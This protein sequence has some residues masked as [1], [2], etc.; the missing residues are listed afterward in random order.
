M[1]RAQDKATDDLLATA[2]AQQNAAE[3]GEVDAAMPE[4]DADLGQ[5][6]GLAETDEGKNRK[7]KSLVPAWVPLIGANAVAKN[8]RIRQEAAA[9][10]ESK[11]DSGHR[12]WLLNLLRTYEFT[13]G[14]IRSTTRQLEAMQLSVAGAQTG[15]SALLSGIDDE[16]DAPVAHD[17]FSGYS[18]KEVKA[19]ITS[20]FG[21]VG[22]GKSSLLKTWAVMRPLLRGHR[23]VVFDKKMHEDAENGAGEGQFGEYTPLAHKLGV[24]PIRLVIGGGPD[25]SCVNLLDPAILSGPD[26]DAAS[27][28]TSQSKLLRAVTEEILGRNLSPGEGKALRIAHRRALSEAKDDGRVAVISDVIEKL[29]NPRAVDAE[30]FGG[31]EEDLKTWGR[32]PGME[33]ERMVEDDLVGLFDRETSPDVRLNSALTVFDLSALPE[34]GPALPVVMTIINTW[35]AHVLRNQG[36]NR[37]PTWLVVEEAWHLVHGSF[38]KVTRDNVKLSRGLGLASVFAFHHLTDIPDDSPAIAMIKD[39]DTVFCYR[40]SRRDDAEAVERLFDF[41]AGSAHA[42]TRLSEGVSFCKIGS[43]RPFVHRHIRSEIEESVS[44]TDE[45][46]LASGQAVIK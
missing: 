23:V 38:A 43:R 29:F 35:L 9:A 41:P 39:S 14:E 28:T 1:K 25:T 26:Q 3:A 5:P 6:V 32:D 19:P 31:T 2:H 16:G 12:N 10:A 24:K 4:N 20:V 15:L 7:N 17:P 44:N 33:L 30:S 46:M 42:L 45:A 11:W 37:V 27:G 34:N 18:S 13:R 21:S 8:D 40:Q 22:Y 36:Q